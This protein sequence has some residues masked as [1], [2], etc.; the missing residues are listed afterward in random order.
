MKYFKQAWNLIKQEKLFSFIYI[1]GTGLSITMVMVLSIVFYIRLANIYPETNRDRILVAKLGKTQQGGGMNS[2]ALSYG[3]IKNCFF[4]LESAEAV[5]AISINEYEHFIQLID[6]KQQIQVSIKLT[7]DQFWTVFPF[8]FLQGKPFT[9]EDVQSGIKTAVISE[10]LSRKLFGTTESIGKHI[11]LDFDS[12]RVA[13]VVKDA[14]RATAISY[15]EM[16]IPYSVMPDYTESW[17]HG[18]FLGYM[19]AFMLAPSVHDLNKLKDEALENV[20]RY[21]ANYAD[22][23]FTLSGQPDKFWQSSFRGWDNEEIDFNKFLL[24]Y[25]VIFFVL[26]FVPAVSLSGMT[27]SRMERRLSEIGVRRT[28]GAPKFSL[29]N[30]IISENFLFTLLGGFVGLLFS[31]LLLLTTRDWILKLTETGYVEQLPDGAHVVLSPSMLINVP[32]FLI[33]LLVCFILNLLSALIPAWRASRQPII[34]SLNAK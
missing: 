28:F 2:S 31:Y 14:S 21:G 24:Q 18:D 12:Y 7:D 8:R 11:S 9:K 26:L 22:V 10:S 34:Y 1:I 32:I 4:N 25:G 3:L 30:Q 19:H 29:M 6:G 27:D 23:T 13:G 5:T 20:K 15:A 33:A 17:G 16:W